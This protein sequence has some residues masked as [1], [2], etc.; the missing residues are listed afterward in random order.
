M[1]C[2]AIEHKQ[3][4]HMDFLYGMDVN[5]LFNDKVIQFIM[6]ATDQQNFIEHQIKK[7]IQE[8]NEKITPVK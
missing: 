7:S 3:W 8:R 6:D 4:N 2:D 5:S 1:G